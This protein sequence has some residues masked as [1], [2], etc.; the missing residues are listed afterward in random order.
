ME[1]GTPDHNDAANPST[2]PNSH[3]KGIFLSAMAPREHLYSFEDPIGYFTRELLDSMKLSDGFRASHVSSKAKPEETT[4]SAPTDNNS[5]QL[6]RRGEMQVGIFFDGTSNDKSDHAYYTNIAKL[7]EAYG[8]NNRNIFALYKRGVGTDVELLKDFEG[9]AFGFGA[10][11]RMEGMLFDLQDTLKLY[12]EKNNALPEKITIDLFGFSRGASTARHFMNVIKQGA[13]KLDPPYDQIPKE[14]VSFRFAG[15]ADTIGSY[16]NPGDNDDGSY[17]Y[18]IPEGWADRIVHLVA[19][20]EYRANF[21]I[22][23]LFERQGK[24]PEDQ[25]RGHY[26]EDVVPGAHSDLG[27]GYAPNEKEH[28][29][30]NNHL[31]RIYLH[32]FLKEATEAGAP[33]KSME[34]LIS[35]SSAHWHIDQRVKTD[36]ARLQSYYDTHPGLE[37]E[38]KKL[39]EIQRG[40]DYAR[41]QLDR[42]PTIDQFN[43]PEESDS[44][45]DEYSRQ[46][47]ENRIEKLEQA[48]EGQYRDV[49]KLFGDASSTE[50]Y[51]DFYEDFR[52]RYIHK[53]HAPVNKTI[54][55]SPELLKDGRLRREVFHKDYRPLSETMRPDKFDD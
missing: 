51:L 50:A 12:K 5:N 34:Q 24:V 6:Q 54:G 41:H 53:S 9:K 38:H 26:A 18:N 31:S 55:M 21:D 40:L 32:R 29:V 16:Y 10:S 2:K 19:D 52:D 3:S 48:A 47:L 7:E 17:T 22:Q 37:T 33:F 39:R 42:I 13:F 44:M 30:G 8:E 49:A 15:L 35:N 1:T 11:E 27:G 36:Y 28:G 45:T 20:N 46:R 25:T 14:A 43:D 23:S 4:P